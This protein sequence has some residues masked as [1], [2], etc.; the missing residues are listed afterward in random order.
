VVGVTPGDYQQCR[1][2]E[3]GDCDSTFPAL[4]HHP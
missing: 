1:P 4:K 2:N 3:H